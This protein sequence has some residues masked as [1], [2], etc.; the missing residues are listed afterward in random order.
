MQTLALQI[1]FSGG[2]RPEGFLNVCT[3][4]NLIEKLLPSFH[5]S[6]L[7][8]VPVPGGYRWRALS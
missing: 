8:C 2:Q 6:P 4:G 1:D 5:A 7:F 3:R